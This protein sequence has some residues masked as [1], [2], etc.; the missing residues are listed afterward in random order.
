M[1]ACESKTHLHKGKGKPAQKQES[2]RPFGLAHPMT[3][4][5][6]D[7]LRL[8]QINGLVELAGVTQLGGIRDARLAVLA[9]QESA[10]RRRCMRLPTCELAA[11][12]RFGYDGGRH[13]RFMH[14]VSVA[15]AS[16]RDWLLTHRTVD[17]HKMLE[18]DCSDE[19]CVAL[20]EVDNSGGGGG[21]QGVCT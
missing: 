10:A 14:Y 19:C 9:P 18:Q 7:I 4:L 8:R 12:A 11:D 21:I 1:T 2:Y 16:D 20:L 15:G 13:A 3:S 6:S 5:R 17:G